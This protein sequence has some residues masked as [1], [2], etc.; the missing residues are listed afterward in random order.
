MIS[1][2]LNDFVKSFLKDKGLPL[3]EF[4]SHLLA[5]D[6]S[7][8]LF[9]RLTTSYD[10]PT[11]VIMENF[12]AN[13]YLKKENLAY[14]MIGKHLFK[15]GLPIPEIYRFNLAN[16]W[17]ILEDVGGRNLQD[18]VLRNK[19]RIVVYEKILDIL[20]R[21]QIEGAQDFNTE[22]C[23]QTK[24]YDNFVMRRHEADYFRD[25]FL[26]KYLG[27]K[28]DWPELEGPFDYLSSV[29]SKADNQHLMHRDFQSR[30]IIFNNDQLGILDWQGARL[31]PLSY[32]LA[33]LLIDPYVDLSEHEKKHLYHQYLLLLKDYRS[34]WIEPF[35]KYF[36]YLAIQRNLQ[37]LGAF[38]FLTRVRGKTYFE[39]YISSALK[40]LY[41]LLDE[42]ADPG[43]S[44]LTDIVRSLVTTDM[45]Q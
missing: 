5:G 12:P 43:L 25:A 3:K 11:F 19:N 7:K 6:G 23:C 4:N 21:L 15:K 29:A 17:F 36:P 26:S 8:R 33:S 41:L 2:S 18:K 13:E 30:N 1:N 20:F 24:I 22:W 10:G 32:D 14:L 35:Q 31:G 27:M 38:S 16:G 44:Y 37:I 42:L 45:N 39:G 9:M 28:S 34:E 40:S